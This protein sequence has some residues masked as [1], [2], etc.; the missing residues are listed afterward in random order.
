MRP[1]KGWSS[2]VQRRSGFKVRKME[3]MGAWR[4]GFKLMVE[5]QGCI[6]MEMLMWGSAREPT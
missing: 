6:M 2:S 5:V 4:P 3:A 1:S